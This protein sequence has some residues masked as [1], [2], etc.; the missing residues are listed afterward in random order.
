MKNITHA[1]MQQQLSLMNKINKATIEHLNTKEFW[2]KAFN[3]LMP[4]ENTSD[5][6]LVLLDFN[7]NIINNLNE[8]N[9][10]ALKGSWSYISKLSLNDIMNAVEKFEDN[11]AAIADQIKECGNYK[12]IAQNLQE[13]IEKQDQ[14]PNLALNNHLVRISWIIDILPIA[15]ARGF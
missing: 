8:K 5:F 15:K 12:K 3:D 13:S 1:T 2:E 6:I 9:K 7:S 4:R 11:Y 14:S 10:A